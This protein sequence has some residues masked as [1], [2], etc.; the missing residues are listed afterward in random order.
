MTHP[1]GVPHRPRPAFARLLTSIGN[2]RRASVSI[3]VGLAAPVLVG[4]AAMAI[5]VT[6]WEATRLALQ[7]AADQASLAAAVAEQIGSSAVTEARAIAAA[8]GYVHG[9]GTTLVSLNRPPTSGPNTANPMAVEV[10]ISHRAS[11]VLSGSFLESPPLLT[12]RSVSAPQGVSPSGGMCLMALGTTGKTFNSNGTT[13]ITFDRCNI[14]N[15]STATDSTDLV[16]QAHVT[17]Y[18]IRLAGNRTLSGQATLVATHTLAV[19]TT[20]TADP[21]ASRTIPA[22]SGCNQTGLSVTAA[23]RTFTAGATPYV[24]CNGLSIS[25]SGIVTF[26]PGIYIFDRGT[27]SISGSKNIIATGGVTFIVTSATGSGIGDFTFSGTGNIDIMAPT[28]GPA[29]GI[30]MWLDRRA[31]SSG[32]SISGN[33]ALNLT[34]ALYAPS[35]DVTWSGTTTGTSPC[36][37]LLGKKFSISGTVQLRSNC[38]SVGIANPP[39]SVQAHRSTAMV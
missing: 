36:I 34:G 32:V 22:F 5:D 27:L 38:T 13:D 7:G 18:D 24:F 33:R 15:N 2:N 17:G 3:I 25:G 14:Y 19:N 28:T 35:V 31:N 37:Q 26:T 12:A 9:V 11:S 6:R 20:P 10:V 29:A 39:G 4:V 21:Y 30:G 23:S 8:N 16:G 1:T